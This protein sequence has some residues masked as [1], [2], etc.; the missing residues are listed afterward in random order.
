MVDCSRDDIWEQSAPQLLNSIAMSIAAANESNEGYASATAAP[1]SIDLKQARGA[2]EATILK[3]DRPLVVVF[4]EV[5]YITPGSPTRAE[6]STEFN[7]FWRNLRSI[8]QECDRQG[9]SLIHI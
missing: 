2:L 3:C 5:D 1:D 4:D 6:W 8:Y 9:L 7:S